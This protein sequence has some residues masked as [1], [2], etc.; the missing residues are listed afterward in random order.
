MKFN[1]L[2]LLVLIAILIPFTTGIADDLNM[3][4]VNA[5]RNG[6]TAAVKSC[7]AKG[8]DVNAKNLAGMT[9]LGC[10]AKKGHLSAVEA[11]L[12]AG[13]DINTHY[14]PYGASALITAAYFNRPEVLKL[15]ISKG[16]DVNAKNNWGDTALSFSKQLRYS[17]I[18][19]ILE[20]AG[21][22]E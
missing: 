3:D 10:A 5:A 11:L 18:Q 2:I 16:A 12:E 6:D 17:E 7:L 15:L 1:Q 14:D 4:L 22:K 13:A 19:K 21:A 9:A 20:E 8:A